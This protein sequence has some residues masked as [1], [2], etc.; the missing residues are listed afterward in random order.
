M[1]ISTKEKIVTAVLGPTNTG[2]TH[3]AMERLL[4]HG[5]G[6]IGFPLRLLAR[7]NY[8]RA[9][10]LKGPRQ[11]AL[12]T[13]EEKI[14][15]TYAKYFFCT[16]E[17]MPVNKRVDFLAIDEI[18]LCAD[19][20]RGH[21]FT[22]RLLHARGEQETMFMGSEG[23]WSLLKKLVPDVSCITR[24]RFSKL[25][26]TGSRK[27]I[28]LPPRSAVVGFSAG[29]VYALAE[30]IRRQRGGAAIVMGALS[31]RT[32]NAQV[33]MFQNGDVDYL[34]ATDAI[35]MGLNMDVDHIAF[36]SLDKFDGTLR[37]ILTPRELA[38][39]AGRAGRYMRD[40]TFGVTGDADEIH[41]S[42]IEQLE[43]HRF[44][45][46]KRFQ[47]RNSNLVF[48]SVDSLIESLKVC[49]DSL[50]LEKIRQPDDE[51][52]FMELVCEKDVQ[53]R[54]D[55]K[56]AIELLWQVCQIPDF[57]KRTA[58]GHVCLLSRIFQSINNSGNL[59]TE[60]IAKEVS[61][62]ANIDGGID[63]LVDRIANIRIWT[64]IANKSDWLINPE[65]WQERTRE[66]EDRLSDALHERLIQR[67][68][69]Q[70]TS[71]L[72]KKLKDKKNL[73]S[74][75]TKEGDVMVEGHFVGRI[76]GF[77]FF[78]D[79]TDNAIAG[80]TVSA[81]AYR[82]LANE[83]PRRATAITGTS[84]LR[85]ELS[86]QGKIYWL[87]K[88][89]TQLVGRLIPG[90][91]TLRPRAE[92]VAS[93]CLAGSSRIAVGHC[94]Q[95][96]LNEHVRE[97]LA[98]LFKAQ[99]ENLTGAI[100]GL[101]F[102]LIENGGVLSRYKVI[103][104]L[105]ALGECD[106][107]MLR[108]L[109]IKVGRLDIFFPRL[110]RPKLAGL[111]ALLWAIQNKIDPVPELPPPGRVSIDYKPE[112]PNGFMRAAGFKRAG[113]LMVRVDI[114]ERIIGML[115][116]RSEQGPFGLDSNILNTLGCSAEKAVLVLRSLGY[117][118]KSVDQIGELNEVAL[119]VAR[120]PKHNPRKNKINMTSRKRK[121]RNNLGPDTILE[122]SPFLK[123]REMSIR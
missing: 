83:I 21:I 27:T 96:W 47:W 120:K 50:N 114:L 88:G 48:D 74:S 29:D 69:D 57:R 81:A 110:L 43:S 18:Q 75:V 25:T 99:E 64:Y 12:I 2:K 79:I 42:I 17:S 67:F 32:R 65:D 113:D 7:E 37:R 89:I 35:G 94:I 115:K 117:E 122:E 82:A 28:R 11:V 9:V 92:L 76:E 108:R 62:M 118:K 107:I 70:R 39:I 78:P 90:K 13:G 106:Y 3:L 23:I 104:Q 97:N 44:D 102:Q 4:A 20:D 16:V 5:S 34:V 73:Q 85:F 86:P 84:N 63:S 58:G 59:N 101:I 80:R 41:P 77:K 51:K 112:I 91:D 22:E 10:E 54:L 116:F 1:Q 31:P 46:I 53:E 60:W 121:K 38:Q 61:R 95:K 71:V 30:L 68:V 103:G 15:P 36:A 109:N 6:M 66:I 93:D 8:D 49:P 40:G 72:V 111:V 45:P 105:K 55:D 24:P 56:S 33:A 123:L 19:L 87:D 26:Y 14:V 52:F 119:Y 100:R 98:P